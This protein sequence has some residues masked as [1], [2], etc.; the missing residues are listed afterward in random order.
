MVKTNV[1]EEIEKLHP[2]YFFYGTES[3][4]VEEA[5]KKIQEKMR[6]DDSPG[7]VVTFD[8]EETP[9]QTVIAEAETTSL[10][11]ETR[12][13]VGRNATFVTTAKVKGDLVHQD[14]SLISYVEKPFTT[15]IVV[16]IAN[17][18]ALDKRKKITKVLEQHASTIQFQPL[19]E[20]ELLLWLSNHLTKWNVMIEEDAA[21]KL[22]ELVGNSLWLFHHECEKLS[23]YVG[24]AGIITSSIV[25][26]LVPRTLE[27]DVFKLTNCMMNQ[28]MDE[29][30]RLWQ[31]LLALSQEPLRI[32]ALMTRQL[33]LT[34]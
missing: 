5:L 23:T 6:T 22:I 10:F 27:Q 11:G 8:L 13:I 9:I 34:L 15:N 18:D 30:L 32:L 19:K 28:K 16:L 33:R 14:K 20:R 17:T 24:Q 21:R 7:S 3:F 12:L 26:E 1:I 29:A 4:L 25:E 2:V 31:D